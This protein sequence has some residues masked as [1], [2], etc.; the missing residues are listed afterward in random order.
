MFWLWIIYIMQDIA[1]SMNVQ[2]VRM[3]ISEIDSLRVWE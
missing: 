3:V 2:G 1:Q